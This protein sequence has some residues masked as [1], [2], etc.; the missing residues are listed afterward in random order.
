MPSSNDDEEPTESQE[1][2]VE[3]ASPDDAEGPDLD[4]DDYVD[5]DAEMAA[6]VAESTTE[7][8]SDN[9]DDSDGDERETTTDDTSESDPSPTDTLTSGTSVGDM[10][11]NA[12]GMGATLA[13]QQKGSGVEDRESQMEEY[14]ALARQ[15]DLDQ[16]V[17]E[18]VEA[19]GGA[20]ELTPGQGIAIATGMFAMT[21]LTE[22]PAIIENMQEEGS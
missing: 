18:W 9:S 13:R 5:V 10:Y 2:D 17:D 11:C 20:D 6:A 7:D 22:D 1:G 21:V 19:H 15:L 12:L 16:F 3:P 4:D 14:G 8:T